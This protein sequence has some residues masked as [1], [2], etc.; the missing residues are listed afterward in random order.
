M[1][2]YY[3]SKLIEGTLE[4]VYLRVKDVL[5]EYGF[6][7][8]SEIDVQKTMKE[9]LDV[10]FRDYLILGACNPP[11]AFRALN[12]EDRIGLLLPCNVIVQSRGEGK[13]EVSAVDP[14]VSMQ[15]IEN[16]ELGSVAGEVRTKLFD[17]IDSL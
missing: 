17:A 16:P 14:A 11:N 10:E 3:N 4:E 8:I 15:M 2:Y 6:G 7:I 5:K 13:Y 1:N 12:L 9:K